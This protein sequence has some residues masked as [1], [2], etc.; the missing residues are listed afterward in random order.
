MLLLRV[1]MA[2]TVTFLKENLGVT[3]LDIEFY[4]DL[5][6]KLIKLI[7]NQK[8]HKIA[9]KT[10]DPEENGD[11]GKVKLSIM[12]SQTIKETDQN[13]RI[14][15]MF[16]TKRSLPQIKVLSNRQEPKQIVTPS[17]KQGDIAHKLP[18]IEKKMIIDQGHMSH[19]MRLDH[20]SPNSGAKLNN[21]TYSS[22]FTSPR[23]VRKT[24]IHNDPYYQADQGIPSL[25]EMTVQTTGPNLEMG[26]NKF[27]KRKPFSWLS[28]GESFTMI[29]PDQV[30]LTRP[31]L[32][33]QLSVT[34]RSKKAMLETGYRSS[35]ST[36]YSPKWEHNTFRELEE[37]PSLQVKE[38]YLLQS[39]ADFYRKVI[40][41]RLP[42]PPPKLQ[43]I[44]IRKRTVA[45]VEQS[46]VS[47]YIL[48]PD[49]ETK[50]TNRN[51]HDEWIA[52]D[53]T[54][55]QMSMYQPLLTPKE[56]NELRKG[57]L[58]QI[59]EDNQTLED[60]DVSQFKSIVVQKFIFD[61]S[62]TELEAIKK[63]IL[64]YEKRDQGILTQAATQKAEP[65]TSL[66]YSK[67]QFDNEN[68]MITL[69]L[70]TLTDSQS[71]DVHQI[72]SLKK[73][74]ER[75][76]EIVNKIL[77]NLDFDGQIKSFIKQREDKYLS[78]LSQ[79]FN[80]GSL[81]MVGQ[82]L[83][84]TKP[85]N[86]I[87]LKQKR[88]LLRQQMRPPKKKDHDSNASME[89]ESSSDDSLDREVHYQKV[90]NRKVHI[91]KQQFLSL[92]IQFIRKEVKRV[93]HAIEM[94][95][96]RRKMLPNPNRVCNTAMGFSDHLMTLLKKN[97]EYL[98]QDI[99]MDLLKIMPAGALKELGSDMFI[100]DEMLTKALEEEAEAERRRIEEL[101]KAKKKVEISI[102]PPSKAEMADTM[103]KFNKM[104]EELNNE[105]TDILGE[106]Q[107][108]TGENKLE[109]PDPNT[110]L[111]KL[112]GLDE[113]RLTED[114]KSKLKSRGVIFRQG[115]VLMKDNSGNVVDLETVI[116]KGREQS[117]QLP[118][119]KRSKDSNRPEQLVIPGKRDLDGRSSGFGSNNES[120][121]DERATPAQLL[122]TTGQIYDVTNK[123][124]SSN[125]FENADLKS[126][127]KESLL[128]RQSS[129]LVKASDQFVL[130]EN[131][132]ILG[133][134]R[135]MKPKIFEVKKLTFLPTI[136]SIAEVKRPNFGGGRSKIILFR[137][138]RQAKKCREED[139]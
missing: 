69:F 119:S 65:V 112:S 63:L 29:R 5:K 33:T 42:P 89:S 101:K 4:F 54:K 67:Q 46:E 7:E 10:E 11:P 100:Y 1:S 82:H 66:G 64:H 137:N 76:L 117:G 80:E 38:P 8:R 34:Q 102:L 3:E 110:N 59:S 17:K 40:P 52:A 132:I 91:D 25:T 96:Y 45:T 120:H 126:D 111:K 131:E 122:N 136:Y 14:G 41:P 127:T 95:D 83:T 104:A 53:Y 24:S 20:T 75:R 43:P 99:K 23:V 134:A 22:Q 118:S 62:K 21:S 133:K 32:S 105:L 36:L 61:N 37:N 72:A 135:V 116:N 48:M 125:G 123:L 115:R 18:E 78:Q 86:D 47:K 109:E 97:K 2:N 70:Q 16:E 35:N 124:S 56:P 50:V 130:V 108:Q 88:R 49:D 77:K 13:Q 90:L 84:I 71:E 57:S 51:T 113:N 73:I 60:K 9:R 93:K 27:Y 12:E 138:Y 15:Y 129:L 31:E 6:N 28:H 19:S 58:N 121:T 26:N 128:N 114:Q 94:N 55:H 81:A 106:T 68:Q 44:S 74:I 85:K 87:H 107:E 98:P 39:Q 139:Q 79:A 103:N 92:C 30:Y